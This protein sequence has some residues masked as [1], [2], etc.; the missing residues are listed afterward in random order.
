MASRPEETRSRKLRG[1]RLEMRAVCKAFGTIVVLTS[2]AAAQQ[3]VISTYAGGVPMSTPSPGAGASI[4][5]ASGVG[6]DAAGNV[7]FASSSLNSVFK[8]DQSGTITRVAGN[9]SPPPASAWTQFPRVRSWSS[10]AL[11][12]SRSHQRHRWHRQLGDQSHKDPRLHLALRD[13][14]RPDYSVRGCAS[15]PDPSGERHDR[16][17]SSDSA[18]CG[19]PRRSGGGPDAGER[20]DSKRSAAGRIC[21]RRPA[22]G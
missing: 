7:Y 16:R 13:R 10:M 3:Y 17:N 20:S 8:L 9:T 21:A 18:I 19:A 6:T 22:S 14:R 12:S 2:L 1:D 15:S 11:A 4:G 5:R